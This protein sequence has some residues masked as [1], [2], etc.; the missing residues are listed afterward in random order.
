MRS[1]QCGE[2]RFVEVQND[3]GVSI[4]TKVACKEL[5]YMPLIPQF[6]HL[7]ISKNTTKHM[8]WHKEVI[9][10]NPDLM[11]HPADTDSWKALDAFGSSFASEARNVCISLAID[12]F[13]PLNLTTPSYSC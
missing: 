9:H 1:I 2:S 8:R 5:C 11:A 7:F 10:D 6:K 13:L 3:D 12:G 4:M